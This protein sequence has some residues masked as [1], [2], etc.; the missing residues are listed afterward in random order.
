MHPSRT[1]LARAQRIVVKIGSRALSEQSGLISSL[2]REIAE[3]GN[4]KRT[5]VIVTSGAIALGTSRLGYKKRPKEMGKLQAAAA[6]GQTVLMQR[7]AEAFGDRGRVIAQVLLTHSDLADR[8]RV[9]NARQA[10]ASLL[11]AG[12]IPIINENDTVATDEI[13]F[14]DNDQLAAMVTPLVG[15]DLLLLLTDVA[16]VLDD[17]GARISVMN[18]EAKIAALPSDGPGVG[19]MSSKVEA[20]TTAS[21]AGTAVVVGPAHHPNVIADILAGKDLG[22]L[23]PPH[24]TTLRARQHWI[25]YTLRPR[26]A[27][28]VDDGAARAIRSGKSSLLPVGV[29]GV[30][31]EFGVGDPVRLMTAQGDEVGRG[32][33]RMGSTDAARAAG[34]KG[35]E[36]EA[37]F[38]QMSGE[39]IVVVHRDDLVGVS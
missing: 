21:R 38:S 24:A 14:G 17:A 30:R 26:G 8:E 28:I 37:L 6:A 29:I 4:A 9:N 18:G 22:T 32:L 27:V 10:L 2:A 11:D 34:K 15:A 20:A 39:A 23:F 36:L 12:A 33:A 35:A 13:R 16:G 7:Y 5:F 25:M 1:A 31:G 19:G 3:L